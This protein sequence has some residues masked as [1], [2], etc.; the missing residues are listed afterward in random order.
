MAR[1]LVESLGGRLTLSRST[2]GGACFCVAL[3]AVEQ[4]WVA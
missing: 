3:P 1:D 4:T 2:S